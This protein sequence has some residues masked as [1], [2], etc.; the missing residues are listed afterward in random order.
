MEPGDYFTITT[1]ALAGSSEELFTAAAQSSQSWEDLSKKSLRVLC[2][3]AVKFPSLKTR[4]NKPTMRH[5][6]KGSR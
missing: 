1:R 5:Q 4:F 6:K 2:G 3:S